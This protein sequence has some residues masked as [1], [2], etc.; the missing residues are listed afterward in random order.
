MK[1]YGGVEVQHH[2]FLAA[3]ALHVGKEP[4]GTHCTGGWMDR[5]VDLGAVAK[6]NTVPA[7]NQ[8]MV[9]QPLA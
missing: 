6:T 4:A 2:A 8:T 7:G 3:A 1:T 9:V 5:R